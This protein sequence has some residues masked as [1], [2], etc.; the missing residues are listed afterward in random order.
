MRYLLLV[1]YAVLTLCGISALVK[2]HAINI[3][4]LFVF[5]LTYYCC[6]RAIYYINSVLIKDDKYKILL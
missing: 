1:I 4:T 5:V 3:E 6:N 2:M